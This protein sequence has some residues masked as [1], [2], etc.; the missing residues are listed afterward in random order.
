MSPGD[1]APNLAEWPLADESEPT[2]SFDGGIKAPKS[3]LRRRLLPHSALKDLFNSKIDECARKVLSKLFLNFR[4]SEW[5]GFA[6]T[7]S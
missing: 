1:S 4:L 7:L 5:V 2:V 3:Q 6:T